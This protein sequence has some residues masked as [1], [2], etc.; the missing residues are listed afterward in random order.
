MASKGMEVIRQKFLKKLDGL[1][2]EFA[3]FQQQLSQQIPS[4]QT[5]TALRIS[6]HQIAGSAKTF[7]FSETSEFAARAERHLDQLLGDIEASEQSPQAIADKLHRSFSELI[8]HAEELVSTQMQAVVEEA[9]LRETVPETEVKYTVLIGDDDTLVID[10]IRQHLED[11]GCQIIAVPDGR[12]VLAEAKNHQPDLIIQDINMPE[13][14]GFQILKSLKREPKTENIPVI[15]L[16][17]RTEDKSIIEGISSGAVDYIIKPFDIDKLVKQVMTALEKANTQVLL[18]DDDAVVN[19]LLALR[20]RK[21]GYKVV[22]AENGREA[23]EKFQQSPPD[24]MLL[25]IMMPGMD[26]LAVL[27]QLKEKLKSDVPIVMLTAKNQ[28]ENAITS[29]EG[30]AHDYIRKPFD[31]DELVARVSAILKRRAVQQHA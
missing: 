4:T 17:K 21:Q 29:F 3:A 5:L 20:F 7:G 10:L 15:M 6:V 2:P 18:V 19:E 24:V 13:I 1:L 30:G 9:P 31:I 12:A 25:D 11:K 22:V 26:G 27:S 28:T 16:T 14:S 8:A 23:L